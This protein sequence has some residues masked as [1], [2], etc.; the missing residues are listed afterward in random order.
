MAFAEEMLRL[1]KLAETDKANSARHLYK[2]ALGFLQHDVLWPCLETGAVLPQLAAMVIIFLK[3]PP[4]FKKNITGCFT[5]PN[6]FEKAM[7]QQ[8]R[9]KILKHAVYL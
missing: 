9:Q 7:K 8:Q 5:A 6:Y 1:Q 3:M 2:M 4:L